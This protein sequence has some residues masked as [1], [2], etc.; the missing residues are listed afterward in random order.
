MYIDDLSKYFEGRLDL[1]A[2]I[3]LF[4]MIAPCSFIFKVIGAPLLEWM[5][6]YGSSN[7]GKSSSGKIVLAADGNENNDD[8]NL[9]ISHIDTIARFGET[10]SKTTFP[11]LVDDVDLTDNPN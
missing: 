1:L 10:V 4:A 2:H 9:S 5:H 8:F 6:P 11:K 7:A 3:L